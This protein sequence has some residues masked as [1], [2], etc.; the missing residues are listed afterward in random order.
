MPESYSRALVE[1]WLTGLAAGTLLLGQDNQG[2]AASALALLGEPVIEP[3]APAPPPAPQPLPPGYLSEHFTLEEFTRSDTATARGIDNTPTEAALAELGKLADTL[4]QVRK[5]LGSNPVFISSGYR[6]PEL[7][8]AVGGAGN[9]AHL[10][11]AAAD[12]TVPAFG[13]PLDVCLALEQFLPEL[14]ID[15]LI[16]ENDSWIHLGRA[17]AGSKP[18]YQCLTIDDGQ[19]V[20]GIVA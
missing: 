2:L 15:Q 13:S 10:Y 14:E 6:C 7:N 5:L 3:P 20:E 19:T 18:R 12:F 4:E 8:A 9:S 11:G 1:T 17:P 16:Y